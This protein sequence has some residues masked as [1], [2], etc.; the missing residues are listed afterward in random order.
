MH[1]SKWYAQDTATGAIRETLNGIA[2]LVALGSFT[3]FRAAVAYA[4]LKGCTLLKKEVGTPQWR[5]TPKRWLISIDYG[6]TEPAALEFLS[7]H[8]RHSEVR[9]PNGRE[10]VKMSGFMP[11]VPFHPKAYMVDDVRTGGNTVLGI[12]VGSGNLTASG[13]L[14]GSECGSESYWK[15][16]LSKA[17]GQSM[18]AAYKQTLWFEDAW[19]RA[20]PLE[21]ILKAYRGRWKKTK[22]PIVEDNPELVDLYFGNA[23]HVVAGT[24]AL[25]LA[26]ARALW[27]E[28]GKLTENLGKGEPGNQADLRRGTRVFFGFTPA[29]VAKNTNFGQVVLQNEAF[30]PKSCSVRFGN[31]S[32]DKLNLPIPGADGPLSYDHSII[33]I[34]RNGVAS[35]GLPRFLVRKGTATD[36]GNWKNVSKS[37]LDFKMQSGR[38]YGLLF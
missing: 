4:T 1:G 19:E 6:R 34:E 36:L 32:M 28:S 30:A 17:D 9:V 12:F 3:Q 11:K 31:N 35:N 33:L 37:H 22:P 25:A 15:T 29:A 26:S 16:P 38:R 27:F 14:T 13:L 24:E 20:D 2:D 5:K 7:A 8:L 23:E 21:N 18:A 10:V